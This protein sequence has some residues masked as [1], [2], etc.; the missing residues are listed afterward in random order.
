[1]RLD[2][3]QLQREAA[4]NGFQAEP[5]EKVVH[6]LDLLDAIIGHPFLADRLVLKGGTALNI[7][8][9]DLPRLSMDID[10]NYIGALDRE[11]ML[12]ERPRVEEAIQA[13]CERQG[14]R[15]RR[16]PREHAGGKWRL[17][18]DRAKGDTGS[19]ELDLNFLLRT[20][21]WP[22]VRMDSPALLEIAAQNIPLLDKHE[23]AAGKLSALF[24]RS[25]SR[26]MFDVSRILT[27]TDLDDRKLRLGFV[28]YGAMSSRDW[29]TVSMEDI[30]LEP[31]EVKRR[32]LPLLRS[33]YIPERG[34]VTAWSSRLIEQCRHSLSRILPFEPGEREFLER[35]NGHG[36][37][38]P[39]LI[40]DDSEMQELL[41]AHP[42]LQWKALNVRE[43]RKGKESHGK[44]SR[45]S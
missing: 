37:I 45:I 26:D 35:I 30:G 20:P 42:A 13:A 7:F 8:L 29:R 25:S 11:I 21:L 2:P 34:D 38:R 22:P 44:N 43:Y 19:L 32:L 33:G 40:T 9:Y 12:A 28:A 23:L 5:F 14:L 27:G 16:V 3:G 17:S 31:D 24:S 1:M 6:L 18:Y 41:A 4:D 36:E 15:V 39:D 10:L